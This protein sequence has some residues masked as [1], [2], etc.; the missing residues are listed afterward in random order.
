MGSQPLSDSPGRE[1]RAFKDLVACRARAG[2]ACRQFAQFLVH[3][4]SRGDRPTACVRNTC[5]LQK[6]LHRPV[7][8]IGSVQTQAGDLAM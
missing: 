6:S 3:A 4:D 5:R 2:F 7:F 1:S 8:S